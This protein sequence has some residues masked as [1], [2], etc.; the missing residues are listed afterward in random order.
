M[1]SERQEVSRNFGVRRLV[2]ALD[3]LCQKPDREESNNGK[4]LYRFS[5]ISRP[6]ANRLLTGLTR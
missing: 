4:S 5:P 2:G 1:P 3:Q 6:R